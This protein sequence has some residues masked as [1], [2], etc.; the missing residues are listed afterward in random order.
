MEV[1]VMLTVAKD[2]LSLVAI[3]GFLFTLSLVIHAV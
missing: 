3:S 2:I 1:F